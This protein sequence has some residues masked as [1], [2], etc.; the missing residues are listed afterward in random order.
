[1]KIKVVAAS[2]NPVKINAVREGFLSYFDSVGAEGIDV[3][4][5]VPDQPVGDKETLL[6]AYNRA[7]NAKKEIPGADFW[8]GIE[9]GIEHRGEGTM[10]FAWAVVLSAGKYGEARTTTFML[11]APITGLLNKGDELG[12]AIDKVFNQDNSKQ[13]RGAVGSLTKGQVSRTKLYV[14]AV[15]LALVPFVNPGLF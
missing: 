14:Q 4:S 7:K 5:G 13:K 10:A 8:V 15:Q 9:G 12:T 2:R 11:P 1:M 3:S 6:G